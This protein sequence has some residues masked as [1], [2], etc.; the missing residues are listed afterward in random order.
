MQSELCH[1]ARNGVLAMHYVCTDHRMCHHIV[2]GQ[3]LSLSFQAE[4]HGFGLTVDP[5]K[6]SP[7]NS[8]PLKAA[9]M[10]IL[11]EPA[12]TVSHTYNRL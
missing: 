4:Y 5:S 11:D 8:K 6:L 7:V 9:L 12:F 1:A 2:T 3:N 10:R